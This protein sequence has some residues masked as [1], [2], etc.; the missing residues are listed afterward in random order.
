MRSDDDLVRQAQKGRLAAFD[1]LMVRYQRLVCKIA[2]GHV[3]NKEQALD[4]TQNVFL[5]VYRNLDAVR[6]D[7]RGR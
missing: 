6:N 4:V 7:G 1:R 2:M 3:G 5:K